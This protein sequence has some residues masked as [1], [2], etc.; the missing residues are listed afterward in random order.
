MFCNLNVYTGQGVLFFKDIYFNFSAIIICNSINDKFSELTRCHIW[1]LIL[2]NSTALS[3]IACITLSFVDA[4]GHPL[5][6]PAQDC[7]GPLR[8]E[9]C[10][11]PL[12]PDHFEELTTVSKVSPGNIGSSTGKHISHDLSHTNIFS[13]CHHILSTHASYPFDIN[14][15]HIKLSRRHNWHAC[16]A[17]LIVCFCFCFFAMLKGSQL[18]NLLTIYDVQLLKL[19]SFKHENT[20]S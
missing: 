7:A 1:R 13:Y 5:P 9:N 6:V 3:G 17:F 18:T 12:H 20:H 10:S 11:I 8:S 19:V 2:K 15:C 14:G 16:Q 4:H